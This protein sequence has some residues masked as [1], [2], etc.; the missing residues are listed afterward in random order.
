MM[1]GIA[2]NVTRNPL[3]NHYSNVEALIYKESLRSPKPHIQVRFL[4]GAPAVEMATPWKFKGST[5]S[6][7]ST[8]NPTSTSPMCAALWPRQIERV[9]EL[10]GLARV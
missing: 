1:Q 6:P 2:S 5:T 8:N 4:A 3:Q 7:A 10:L 9:K